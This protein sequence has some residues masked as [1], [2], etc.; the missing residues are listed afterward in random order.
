MYIPLPQA[1][2]ENMGYIRG[3][4]P[5]SAEVKER[6]VVLDVRRIGGSESVEVE[7]RWRA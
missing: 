1:D 5:A 4:R 2:E 7:Y 3:N 6:I